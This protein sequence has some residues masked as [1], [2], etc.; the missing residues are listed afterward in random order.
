MQADIVF[1]ARLVHTG[2]NLLHPTTVRQCSNY[3][4]AVSRLMANVAVLHGSRA[5]AL[6][7][8]EMFRN[9]LYCWFKYFRTVIDVANVSTPGAI[10]VPCLYL[11][12]H[13]SK[14]DDMPP[15]AACRRV[16]ERPY[17]DWSSLCCRVCSK[18]NALSYYLLIHFILFANSWRL[19]NT[20]CPGLGLIFWAAIN[21]TP[22]RKYESCLQHCSLSVLYA[23]STTTS[24][25]K[26]IGNRFQP[27]SWL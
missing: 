21:Q 5:K 11:S 16:F 19:Q 22:T 10:S 6:T 14:H 27:F 20:V 1:D 25:R 3:C 26:I 8:S 12:R 18:S 9:I 15:Q 23:T 13:M 2:L 4:K 17:R 7:T 24:Q